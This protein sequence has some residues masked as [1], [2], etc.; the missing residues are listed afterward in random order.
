MKSIREYNTTGMNISER[1]K[2]FEKVKP[3]PIGKTV[4]ESGGFADAAKA[5][6]V[7]IENQKIVT[8]FWNSMYYNTMDE[9]E[10]QTRIAHSIYYMSFFE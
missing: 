5:V 7:T 9:A 8:M 3:I 10:H 4:F 6:V 1:E 2:L